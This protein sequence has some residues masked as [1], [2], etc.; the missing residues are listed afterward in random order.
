MFYNLTWINSANKTY[1]DFYNENLSD[2]SPSRGSAVDWSGDSTNSSSTN[3]PYFGQYVDKY[4][5]STYAPLVIGYYEALKDFNVSLIGWTLLPQDITFNWHET[6]QLNYNPTTTTDGST[7]TMRLLKSSDLNNDI[8]YYENDKPITGQ[9][10]YDV[11]FCFDKY[12]L[13]LPGP[14]D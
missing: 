1:T 3:T 10:M 5:I 2:E 9:R 13:S 14:Y 7:P 8:L 11:Q 6:E 12:Y 4:G